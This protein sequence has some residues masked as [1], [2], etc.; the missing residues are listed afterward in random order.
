MRLCVSQ[1]RVV[2]YASFTVTNP[3]NAFYDVKREVFS[4][5]PTRCDDVFIIPITK[6]DMDPNTSNRK[7]RQNVEEQASGNTTVPL[8]VSLEGVD[9]QNEFVLETSEGDNRVKGI[10]IYTPLHL[11]H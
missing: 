4:T 8:Y 11:Q 6:A 5:G 7:K 9:E 10:Y 2:F 1:G 3:N